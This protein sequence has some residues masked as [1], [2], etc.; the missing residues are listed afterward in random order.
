LD[1]SHEANQGAH[2]QSGLRSG[3]QPAIMR[4]APVR[5]EL[6]MSRKRRAGVIDI[7][8]LQ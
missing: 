6:C 3:A 4:A 1:S 5:Q 2:R 7:D 8:P